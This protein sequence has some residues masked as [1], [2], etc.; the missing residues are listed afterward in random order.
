MRDPCVAA[1]TGRRRPFWT[2]YPDACGDYTLCGSTCSIPGLKYEDVEGGRTIRT[3]DWL[4]SLILNILNTRA[5]TDLRCP[6]PAAVYGHWSE[7]Y[8]GDG[9]YIGSKLWNAASKSYVRIAS[10]EKAVEAAVNSDM[11]KLVAL[12][13]AVKVDVEA[14]YAGASKISVTVI[15]MTQESKHVLN[16][17]GTSQAGHWAWQ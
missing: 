6:S 3:D 2:T 15:A 17:S 14:K 16:L 5:R 12:G 11:H 10:E 8:R 7:S 13:I 4:R 9:L 1:N